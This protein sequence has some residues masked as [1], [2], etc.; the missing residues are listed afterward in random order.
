M[1][2]LSNIS[3]TTLSG[4]R[5]NCLILFRK[6]DSISQAI[7]PTH[8]N[9]EDSLMIF[10]KAPNNFN[11]DWGATGLGIMLG[12]NIRAQNNVKKEQCYGYI[13]VYQTCH[14][15]VAFGIVTL[16]CNRT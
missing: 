10:G 12:Q 6:I 16:N 2:G 15:F 14:L 11:S 13:Q 8:L 1:F 7:P 5:P 9:I 4:N 3:Q